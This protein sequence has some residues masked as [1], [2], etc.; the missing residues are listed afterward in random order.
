MASRIGSFLNAILSG[1]LWT[2][3]ILHLAL[4][5]GVFLPLMFI[6]NPRRLFPLARFLC[7]NQLLV[8]GCP[9]RVRG[10]EN[11][12]KDGAC[13]LMGNHESLFDIFA[14]IGAI[15]SYATALEAA[16]H[17]DFPVWGAVIRRW[18]VIPL[19]ERRIREALKALDRARELLKSGR[20]VIILPEGHR[21]RSGQLAPLKKGA[22]HLAR[23]AEADV[24]P[25]IF[26]GLYEFQNV[27][28]WR[29]H[30]RVLQ[31]RFC[32]LIP[33]SEHRELPR[34]DLRKK[35]A[36]ILDGGNEETC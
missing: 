15:P 20:H 8:M 17:F 16:Q 23:A 11:F 6:F 5:I 7:R 32:R 36:G 4:A 35:L 34:G 13:L 19:P 10:M 24:L 29:L 25:F 1:V 28:S 2:I 9:L 26:E 14:I 22:F 3:G 30:P 31:V 33:F 18:G 21:T 12:P 27:H